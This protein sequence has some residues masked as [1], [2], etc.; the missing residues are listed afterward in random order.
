MPDDVPYPA[1]PD[2]KVNKEGVTK[3]LH[4]LNPSKAS[5]PDL[6]PA[7]ILKN[8]AFEIAP[9]LTTIF[10]ESFN[11]GTVPRDWR[12]ANVTVIFKKGRE[13]QSLLLQTSLPYQSL[14]QGPRTHNNQQCLK[15]PRGTPSTHR[16]GLRARRSCETQLLTLAHEL[17]SSLD[18][19]H[20]Y[21]L[22]ILDFSKAFDSVPHK[23]LL[24]KMDHYGVRGSTY[25]WVQAFLTDRAQQVHVEGAISD[26]ITVISRVPQ[27]TVLGPL[28]FH[29]FINDLPDCVQSSTRLFAD[30]CIL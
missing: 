22:I 6:I 13:V 4:K 25:K 9:F 16:N 29:L 15:A 12:I 17:V 26:S 1:M 2:I 8:M 24:K 28:S 18:K 30:Y 27:G 11:T 7:R 20:Q 14:L 5:G 3:L 19:K 10:Q 23:R 21:D